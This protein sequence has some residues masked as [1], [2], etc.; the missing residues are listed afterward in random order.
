MLDVDGLV[1]LRALRDHGTVTEAASALGYT[2]SAVSQRVKRL[3][4]RLGA[5]LTAP[6]GRRVVL[7]PAAQRLLDDAEPLLGQ[8]ES[9]FFRVS[10][11]SRIAGAVTVAAF[12]TAIRAGI[13]AALASATMGR[14]D[15]SVR[16]VEADPVDAALRVATG[17]ADVAVL[18]HWRSLP[19][20]L[21]DTLVAE[22]VLDD[23]ADV[24]VRADHPPA[25]GETLS[26]QQ[27]SSSDWVSTGE[28]TLCHEWLMSM[29]AGH[30]LR[31]RITCTS[32]DFDIHL[33]FV[34]AGLAAALVPRL[35]RRPLGPDLVAIP[36]PGAVRVVSVVRRAGQVDDPTLAHVVA[37]L[38]MSLGA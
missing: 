37:H 26:P 9:A 11:S 23:G 15:L 21:P 2:P 8:L 20:V 14:P 28:G 18:H 4:R 32:S 1:A 33:D 38:R 5:A 12:T 19:R 34:R 10:G 16:V 7:T 27:L 3:E 36:A 30:G 6:A 22:H 13:P 25:L 29:F 24:I 31:P 35:G 17:R